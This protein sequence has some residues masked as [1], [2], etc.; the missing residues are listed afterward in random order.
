[1]P[2][3]A[4]G[5]SFGIGRYQPHAAG[6]VL[7]N[8]YGDCKDKANLFN[9]LLHSLKIEANLVLVPLIWMIGSGL[10]DAVYPA[11]MPI[12]QMTANQIFRGY[13]RFIGVGAI[14]TAVL[15]LTPALCIW[16]TRGLRPLLK[17]VRPVEGALAADSLLQS[18]R[19][20]SGT[21]AALSLSVALVIGLGGISKASYES[22]RN[23][24]ESALS[25][26][27]FITGSESITPKT[28]VTQTA[29]T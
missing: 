28:I 27:F 3:H 26:D 2:R 23:W 8:Q 5:G 21:V 7:R 18:P 29:P 15:L 24:M 16:L 22:I 10:S 6:E 11:S 17:W 14:A 1:M 19:R 12:S 4:R 25:P 13:V 9:A 20:T